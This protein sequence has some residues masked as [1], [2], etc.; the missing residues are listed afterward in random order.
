M[1]SIKDQELTNHPVN[2]QF[3]NNYAHTI[4]QG[5]ERH[6]LNQSTQGNLNNYSKQVDHEYSEVN[7]TQP[8]KGTLFDRTI[9]D[10][11]NYEK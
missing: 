2:D 4:T 5:H 7:K 6:D 9:D 10:Y 3:R 8:Y 1:A 11:D